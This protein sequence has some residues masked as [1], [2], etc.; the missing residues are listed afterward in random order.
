[1]IIVTWVSFLVILY[2]AL[3]AAHRSSY[4]TWSGPRWRFV[5]LAMGFACASSGSLGMALDVPW[6]D[7]LF[8]AGSALYLLGNRRHCI[9]EAREELLDA[10]LPPSPPH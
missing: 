10:V 4:R 2:H 1:M 5:T 8:A 7:S 6:A 9:T 3:R